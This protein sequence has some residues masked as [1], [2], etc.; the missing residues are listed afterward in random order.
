MSMV[1]VTTCYPSTNSL[2]SLHT[3]ALYWK[4]LLMQL[5]QQ[6]SPRLFAPV[7]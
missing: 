4:C 5:W 6:Q 1:W 7:Q 2:A 3:R